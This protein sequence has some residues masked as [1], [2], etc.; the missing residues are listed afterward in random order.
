MLILVIIIIISVIA[1]TTLYVKENFKQKDETI[2]FEPK[3][4]INIFDNLPPGPLSLPP[5]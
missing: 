4:E 5:E 3:E 2:K 1:I